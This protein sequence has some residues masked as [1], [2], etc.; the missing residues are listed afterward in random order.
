[1]IRNIIFKTNTGLK[2]LTKDGRDLKFGAIFGWR[3]KPKNKHLLKPLTVKNQM[4]FN[5]CSWMAAAGAKEI[6]EQCKLDERTLVMFGKKRGYIRGDG[7]ANLRDNQKVLQK[8]GIAED[9][10]L[11]G[12]WKKWKDYS[13]YTKMSQE[14]LHNA[15][16]HRIK[17]FLKLYTAN[18]ILKA[19]DNGR[20]VEIGIDWYTGYNIRGG[21]KLP[22][23]IHKVI[24]W[25]VGGHAMYIYDYNLD[26]K[27]QK[28]FVVRNSYGE[29]WGDK[30][31]L[32]LT[33]EML[34]KNI[35]KYGAFI[36]YDMKVD[37]AKWLIRHQGMV[38]KTS[39]SPNVYLI[40]GDRKRK[41]QDMPTMIAHGKDDADI[42][43]VNENYLDEVKEGNDI[44]F[45]D[46]GNV[47]QIKA[48]IRHYGEYKEQFKK[49]FSEL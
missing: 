37:L 17:S 18:E 4:P 44:L 9:G 23:I 41:Y 27:G 36:N 33:F 47:K 24:G 46:G 6:D 2:P 3:Y 26:Y 30:G 25:L 28:V 34:K 39:G 19:L 8:D 31:N 21:F 40:V 43:I 32:Y 16:K 38:V 20:P 11:R 12:G 13:D 1:M 29:S 22:W 10:M 5:T 7:F 15:Q 35:R 42:T 49:Y 14:V 45:W 48:M